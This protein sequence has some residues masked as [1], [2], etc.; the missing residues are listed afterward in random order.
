MRPSHSR[1]RFRTGSAACGLAFVCWQPWWSSQGRSLA[2]LDHAPRPPHLGREQ[3]DHARQAQPPDLLRLSLLDQCVAQVLPVAVVSHR[4]RRGDGLT[5]GLRTG[6]QVGLLAGPA[7]P[8]NRRSARPPSCRRYTPVSRVSSQTSN[9]PRGCSS[10]GP[11]RHLSAAAPRRPAAAAL[12][13]ALAGSRPRPSRPGLRRYVAAGRAA[14]CTRSAAGPPGSRPSHA[15]AA[16]T[17]AGRSGWC[18]R[19][20]PAARCRA[21][22]GR[23]CTRPPPGRGHCCSLSIATGRTLLSSSA[24]RATFHQR[25]KRASARPPTAC[26][27]TA[28]GPGTGRWRA[29]G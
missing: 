9:R 26:R 5:V 1:R 27:G 18:P 11:G 17:P 12:P 25:G 19:S 28:P 15:P 22:P 16:R 4:Q 7:A 29:G 13:R 10:P 24:G 21:A 8:C 3:P 14:G 20:R 23:P 6:G 2:I